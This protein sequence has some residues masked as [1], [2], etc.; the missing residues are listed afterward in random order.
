MVTSEK[1]SYLIFEEKYIRPMPLDDAVKLYSTI[2][3][4]NAEFLFEWLHNI[5]KK[6][7]LPCIDLDYTDTLAMDKTKMTIFDVCVDDVADNF[8]VRDKELLNKILK[9]PWNS[10]DNQFYNTDIYYETCKILYLDVISSVKTYPRYEELKDVF[11]YDLKQVIHS[12][13][14]SFLVN[15]QMGFGSYMESLLY[16]PHG[17]MVILH[18]VMDLMCSPK[19][20]MSELNNV[21]AVFTIAQKVM[22]IGNMLNTYPREIREKD[23]SSPIMMMGLEKGIYKYNDVMKND[24]E[25]RVLTKIE[26]L[27]PH[28]RA[29]VPKYFKEIRKYRKKVQCFDVEE[30]VQALNYVYQM[31]IQ[32]AQYWNLV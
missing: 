23:I 21:H 26:K 13:E 4:R 7:Y 15:S 28:F 18:C 32:R 24:F 12:M 5:Y 19:F 10:Y 25:R 9:I 30:F 11:Y 22:C 17:L 16:V 2:G 6:V 29:L 8:R 14:Y 3:K 31:F 20:K 27:E 1:A